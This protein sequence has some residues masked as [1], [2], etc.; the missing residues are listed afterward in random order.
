M[1]LS[2]EIEELAAVMTANHPKAR[3]YRRPIVGYA[4]AQ[5]P[6]YD[7]LS[8]IIGNPQ[9]HP[10]DM[11]PGARTVIVI[12]LPYSSVV[13]EDMK[14]NLLTSVIYSDAYMYT[15]ALL[16]DMSVQTGLLLKSKGYRYASEPPTENFDHINKTACWGHKANAVI[17]GI[18]TFG[19]NHL[20][21][22]KAGCLGRLTS[23]VTDAYI[24]PGK[25][26]QHSYCLFFQTGKCRKCVDNCPS[27][28]LCSDGSIDKKRCDAYLEG[29]NIH[30]WQQG[31]PQCALGPCA[32]RGF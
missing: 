3:Y 21:I 6:L 15:N 30:D 1:T 10:C 5:D 12:F 8:D 20:L 7:Q 11:L 23:V 19:L 31:C 9:I 24:E 4:S 22:T 29:K 32:M 16:N 27:G 26:P 18:G 2:Q 14:N 17:A 28:A 25:R 13:Y